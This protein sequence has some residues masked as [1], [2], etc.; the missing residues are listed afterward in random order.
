M[1]PKCSP[2]Q[3]FSS[4][5]GLGEIT[6]VRYLCYAADAAAVPAAIDFST[7][8][9]QHLSLTADTVASLSFPCPGQYQLI[10]ENTTGGWEVEFPSSVKWERDNVYVASE[11]EGALDIVR[12]YWDGTTA[13]GSWQTGFLDNLNQEFWSVVSLSG[14]TNLT[15]TG[16]VPRWESALGL[17]SPMVQTTGANQ[18]GYSS[19]SLTFGGG[20][21]SMTTTQPLTAPEGTLCVRA[22]RAV[23]AINRV[24]VGRF[25]VTY[26][27]IAVGPA[28]NWASRVGTDGAFVEGAVPA[29][30]D[31]ALPDH[32]ALVWN[33]TTVFVYVNGLLS[34]S[35]AKAGAVPTNGITLGL[36]VG[37]FANW[38]GTVD[39]VS[40]HN[41]ALTAPQIAILASGF[42]TPPEIPG[43]TYWLEQER[44]VYL[45]VSAWTGQGNTVTTSQ[46]SF[47]NTITSR[48]PAWSAT[49]EYG[50]LLD[51]ILTSL[52][53][54]QGASYWTFLQQEA[55]VV[56]KIRPAVAG[57]LFDNASLDPAVNGAGLAWTA[58]G[59]FDLRIMN[60]T[61]VHV[62]SFVTAPVL[63]ADTWGVVSVRWSLAN[64][65][66]IRLNGVSVGSGV[67]VGAPT[68]TSPI[69]SLRI[70]GTAVSGNFY[71][72]SIRGISFHQKYYDNATV[73]RL[74]AM[75]AAA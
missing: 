16:F 12:F 13:Y 48:Q 50:L 45:A 20:T 73:A 53:S 66:D 58:A 4:P 69:N 27:A 10:V 55:T 54:D 24:V 71:G 25:S 68:M 74:E 3:K 9:V 52:F 64:G 63:P 40:V 62:V 17:V 46:P 70:G 23:G 5:G 18:P 22:S 32:V 49:T 43:N 8:A 28:G 56:L 72:G 59:A 1:T 15:T 6:G 67:M 41:V 14:E 37:G 19:G 57:W 60:G 51:G 36:G 34:H 26:C 75:M 35:Y 61:G 7:S 39:E 38:S 33:A 11:A 21:Q 47:T 42:L 2:R 29:S 44:S 65:F 31:P 30:V